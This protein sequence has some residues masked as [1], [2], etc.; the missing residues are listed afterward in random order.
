MKHIEDDEQER[1]FLWVNLATISGY[2]LRDY[3]FAIPNGGKRN[4]REAARMKRQGVKAGVSDVFVPIP[5][6]KYHGLWIEMKA[7]KGKAKPKVQTNQQEWIERMNGIGYRAVVC[8]G[9][10]EAKAVITEYL[11]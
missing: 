1:L 8:Y 3:I 11:Q 5:T 10:V 4:V 6:L 2:K 9:W 7:P